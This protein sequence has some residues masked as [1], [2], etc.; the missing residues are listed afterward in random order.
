MQKNPL[1]EVRSSLVFII[2]FGVFFGLSILVST[3]FDA[4]YLAT[5]PEGVL[6]ALD[7]Y[8]G[9]LSYLMIGALLWQVRT[10]VRFTR[11]TNNQVLYLV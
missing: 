11:H 8:L 3:L 10:P 9:I 6:F 1:D 5:A 2:F 7:N 4:N